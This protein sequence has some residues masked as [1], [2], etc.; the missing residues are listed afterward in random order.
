M[1]RSFDAHAGRLP[2]RRPHSVPR[3]G[4]GVCGAAAVPAARACGM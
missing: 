4:G 1:R 2:S 3:P